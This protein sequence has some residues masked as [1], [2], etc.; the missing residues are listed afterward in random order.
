MSNKKTVIKSLA[1]ISVFTLIS[2]IMG[3][4]RETM[5]ASKYGANIETDMYT[6][7][8]TAVIF[9]IGALGS[10]LNTTLVPIFSEVEEREGRRGKLKFMNKIMNII[11][12]IALILC[13][14]S[15][16]FAPQITKLIAKGFTGET[17]AYTA[18]LMRIGV[19]II[20][21]LSITYIFSS[22]L[23]SENIFGPYAIMGIPYNL[24]FIIF[25]IFFARRGNINL[26]MFVSV[27]AASMQFLIQLPAV[28]HKRYRYSPDLDFKDPYVAKMFKLIVPILIGSS[29]YQINLVVDKTLASELV[30]GS[31]SVLNYSSKIYL[32]IISVFVMA[33]TTV[34]FPKLSS[35]M[36]RN[37]SQEIRS[38]ISESV[39]IVALITLPATFA[40]VF[41]SY[42]IVEILFQRNMFN[43]TATLMTSG[44]LTFYILGLFF[45][46][47]RMIFEKVFYSMQK[48][49]VPMINGLIAVAV[50][51]AF[52]IILVKFMQ[53]KG[54]AL[55]TS[56]S[57]LVSA[58]TLYISL[59]KVYPDIEIKDNL[60]SLIKILAASIIMALAMYLLFT[61]GV[62]VLGE[63]KIIKFLMMAIS[64]VI[65][66]VIYVISLKALK[67]HALD[68]V[69]NYKRRNNEK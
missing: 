46:S 26:L 55:A 52:D 22:F 47:L 49:K 58:I 27:I 31:I 34:I 38:I 67:V 57:S 61:L 60:I 3:F 63:K 48:T 50:N 51:I 13:A 17:L 44:A 69:L 8:T 21:F 65:A 23:Q 41:L 12:L 30:S 19:P 35:S 39:D 2:K 33:L 40:I 62:K 5:I 64:G 1:M 10:G 16:I 14:L 45:A 56:I 43:E 42:P 20:L 24:V 11:G 37:E 9:L 28:K 59:K 4:F 6:A 15:Y 25:L 7:A 54:L 53:H 66:L 29:A 32:M 18:Y 36:I 68:A